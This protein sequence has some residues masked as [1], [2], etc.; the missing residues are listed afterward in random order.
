MNF[1]PLLGTQ[2]WPGGHGFNNWESKLPEDACIIISQI[3]VLEKILKDFPQYISKLN[4][5]LSLG[6]SIFQESRFEQ[7]RI[8]TKWGCLHSNITNS[9]IVV[10]EK[11]FLTASYQQFPKLL[12]FIHTYI[13]VCIIKGFTCIMWN[14]EEKNIKTVWL[15]IAYLWFV[16]VLWICLKRKFSALKCL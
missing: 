14:I 7:F 15:F 1:E 9:S 5:E 12:S 13:R 2:Y 3:L 8:Y 11:K 10:L 16:H 6:P 4:F